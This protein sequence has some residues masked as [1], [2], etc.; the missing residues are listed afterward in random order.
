ME[1]RAIGA[2]MGLVVR[3]NVN[4]NVIKETSIPQACLCE[5]IY[6]RFFFDKPRVQ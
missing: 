4:T 3:M 1:D 5:Y 2:L 6:E